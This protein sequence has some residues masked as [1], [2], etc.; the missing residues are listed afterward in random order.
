MKLGN[1]KRL[2]ALLITELMCLST[3]REEELVQRA[4]VLKVNAGT[5]PGAD[6]GPVISKEVQT[7]FCVF[8]RFKYLSCFHAT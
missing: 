2:K 4:K 3:S 1:Q 5:N 7:S 8:L 6:L